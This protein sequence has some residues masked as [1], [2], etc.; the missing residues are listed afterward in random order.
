MIDTST[1][2]PEALLEE[3]EQQRILWRLIDELPNDKREVFKMVYDDEMDLHS[4]ASALDIPEGT[5]KSRLYHS[6]VQ[7]RRNLKNQRKQK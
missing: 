4:V 6:R 2:T 3:S 7:L 5:V 1:L